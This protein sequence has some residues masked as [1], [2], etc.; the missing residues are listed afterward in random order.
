M[1]VVHEIERPDLIEPPWGD[2][3]L[4]KA[5]RHPAS[6]APR[7]IQAQRPIHAVHPLVIPRVAVKPESVKT[8]P[9]PPSPV[10]GDEC[11]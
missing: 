11:L 8:F 3:R 4:A 6:R 1:R 9:K 10:I 5:R 7:Q 2:H